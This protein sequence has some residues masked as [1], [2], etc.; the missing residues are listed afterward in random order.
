MQR[1]QLST[2]VHMSWTIIH[3]LIEWAG[4]STTCCGTESSITGWSH[5]IWEC[6]RYLV[7]LCLHLLCPLPSPCLP[8][9]FPHGQ[10][11][12]GFEC[13]GCD[14]IPGCLWPLLLSFE[15][16]LFPIPAS[17]NP[18]LHFQVSLAACVLTR[19]LKH[20]SM[21]KIHGG[22]TANQEDQAVRP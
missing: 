5:R 19:L 4:P 10:F 9:W 12:H 3:L 6:F 17:H 13:S 11:K 2:S 22:D 20:H 7:S 21:H 8:S 14:W 1:T 15:S 16:F 18:G